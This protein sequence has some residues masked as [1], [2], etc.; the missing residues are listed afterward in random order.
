MCNDTDLIEVTRRIEREAGSV[1]KL[2][3][4]DTRAR[5]IQML[6]ADASTGAR[7]PSLVRQGQIQELI[8]QKPNER[9]RI[10]ED[11]AGISGLHV[12]RHEAELRI[13]SAETNIDRLDDILKEL[14]S[15]VRI[16]K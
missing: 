4:N 5:D 1:Y 2:N 12:R 13:K 7:S 16:F 6:F 10:L 11:A 8:D 3:G 15:Q 9:R 14:S